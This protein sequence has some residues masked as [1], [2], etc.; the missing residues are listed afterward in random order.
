MDM[1]GPTGLTRNQGRELPMTKFTKLAAGTLAALTLTVGV[2]A[3]PSQAEAKWKG[4]S[5][6]RQ[7]ASALRPASSRGAAYAAPVLATTSAARLGAAGLLATTLGQLPRFR[8]GL[9]PLLSLPGLRVSKLDRRVR[10]PSTPAPVEM[11]RSDSPRWSGSHFFRGLCATPTFSCSPPPRKSW[12]M[13][14]S[15]RMFRAVS[16]CGCGRA[17]ARCRSRRFPA[18][19]WRSAR[20]TGS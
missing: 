14:G 11:T 13:R 15:A 5:G 16:A 18:R 9:R 1:N 12:P 19:A 20:S 8:E 7:S 17:P 10:P 4:G 3:A 2:L 6:A